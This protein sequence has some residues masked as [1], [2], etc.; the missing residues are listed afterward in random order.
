MVVIPRSDACRHQGYLSLIPRHFVL[1]KTAKVSA[2]LSDGTPKQ[3][4]LKCATGPSARTIC[5]GEFHSATA[6]SS[7][8]PGFTPQPLGWGTYLQD[9]KESTKVFF[10]LS[11]F[12]EMDLSTPP[13]PTEFI[14][15][16]VHLHKTSTS[17]TGKFGFP[18]PTVCGK[19]QRTVTWQNSW[20]TSFTHLLEDVIRYDNETNGPRPDYDA[21]CRQ[22]I[23]QVIPRLLGALGD[24]TPTFIHGDLWENNV[25]IDRH[26]GKVIV[27][28]AGCV[29]AHNEMEFGTW[30]CSWATHFASEPEYML[31][32]KERIKPSDRWRSGTIGTGCTVSI[33]T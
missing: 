13:S 31:L 33:L 7:L 6:I 26:T 1:D 21:A 15:R 20:T 32:Y 14:S 2:L 5:E 4:F 27:F 28:D 3:Y 22:L 24:V 23:D 29:Y 30:R 19:L 17:P 16:L 8:V 11:S 12:H 9:D 18:C 25:G 10:L